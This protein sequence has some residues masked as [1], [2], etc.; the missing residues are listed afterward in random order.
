MKGYQK[1]L[2]KVITLGL[3]LSSGGV[4]PCA[5]AADY[6]G[7][8]TLSTSGWGDTYDKISITMSDPGENCA[9]IYTY[10]RN[11]TTIANDAVKVMISDSGDTYG[12]NGIMVDGVSTFEANK[13]FELTLNS[14]GIN[15]ASG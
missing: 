6:N 4:M 8:G 12:Y 3:L 11:N 15:N 14:T 10:G 5:Q 9:G 2:T 7:T 13:G 1:H